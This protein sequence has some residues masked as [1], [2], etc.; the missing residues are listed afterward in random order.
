MNKCYILLCFLFLSGCFHTEVYQK[1][2]EPL[3]L[4]ETS[5]EVTLFYGAIESDSEYRVSVTIKP[6][7]TLYYDDSIYYKNPDMVPLLQKEG[8]LYDV[9]LE[10]HTTPKKCLT[11]S[12]DDYRQ[13]DIRDFSSYENIGL[14]YVCI[15]R[16]MFIPD[17]MLYRITD[18][19]L[20]QAKP[21]E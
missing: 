9:R 8:L 2:Y 21:C 20:E 19:L 13:H 14:C 16:T 12:G 10:F 6:G 7:D 5:A 11:Y 1:F 3:Y 4:N 18:E 17:G 15:V